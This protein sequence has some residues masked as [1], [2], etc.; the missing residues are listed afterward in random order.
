MT[1]WAEEERARDQSD[2]GAYRVPVEASTQEDTTCPH[3][4]GENH[5]TSS[6]AA[7]STLSAV[8]VLPI[9]TEV[10]LRVESG[11]ADGSNQSTSQLYAQNEYNTRTRR[12]LLLLRPDFDS[13]QNTERPTVAELVCALR[14]CFENVARDN[15]HEDILSW[16]R[17]YI[18]LINS[19]IFIQQDLNIL[20]LCEAM[21]HD[22]WYCD[23]MIQYNFLY[24]FNTSPSIKTSCPVQKLQISD[25]LI[26]FCFAHCTLM[27]QYSTLHT[28]LILVLYIWTYCTRIVST[29]RVSVLY[30]TCLCL[31]LQ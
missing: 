6:E 27:N 30:C 24:S 9:G 19:K 4:H 29:G 17:V 12:A 11:N 10:A 15:K 23:C 5:S 3:P 18:K 14:T 13:R 7:E 20:K 21:V 26:S 2:G 31:V 22:L 25:I 28:V 1:E 16:F 8:E